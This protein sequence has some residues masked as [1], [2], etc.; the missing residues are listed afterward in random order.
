MKKILFLSFTLASVFAF[1]T[2]S[3]WKSDKAHSRL[4]FSIT[5]LGINEVNGNFKDFE[6]TMVWGVCI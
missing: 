6:V 2:L 5:H 1:T 4:G 3:A